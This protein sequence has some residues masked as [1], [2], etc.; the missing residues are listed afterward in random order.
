MVWYVHGRQ[1]SPVVT[2]TPDTPHGAD[3][4]PIRRYETLQTYRTLH[5]LGIVHNDVKLRH[6]RR[7]PYSVNLGRE[8]RLIDFNLAILDPSMPLPRWKS[9]RKISWSSLQ[10]SRLVFIFRPS[11]STISS[12]SFQFHPS[13]AHPRP[14]PI[15]PAPLHLN[16]LP[17]PL[18][19]APLTICLVRLSY[20]PPN[21]YLLRW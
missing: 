12:C 19:T 8:I 21:V 15:R 1:V 18:L 16:H 7:A 10:C 5:S 14:L 11:L 9:R 3:R 6:L 2:I 4:G 17:R 13:C 20:S